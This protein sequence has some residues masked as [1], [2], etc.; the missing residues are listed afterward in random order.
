MDRRSNPLCL[1]GSGR[2]VGAPENLR[3]VAD[4]LDG[5]W[6]N[7]AVR[8]TVQAATCDDPAARARFERWMGVPA[9]SCARHLADL[10]HLLLDFADEARAG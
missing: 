10:T 8:R 2:L 9:E 7:T 4:V 5:R 6:L 1:T 3:D